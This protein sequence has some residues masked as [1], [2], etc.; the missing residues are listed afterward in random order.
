MSK[1]ISSTPIIFET[2]KVIIIEIKKP[3]NIDMPQFLP[4]FLFFFL[5]SDLSI[6]LNFLPNTINLGIRF[7]VTNKAMAKFKNPRKT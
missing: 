2:Q 5:L 1:N 7:F 6:K 3:I 4:Y